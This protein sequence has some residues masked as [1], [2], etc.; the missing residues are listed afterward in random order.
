MRLVD[1]FG[2]PNLP[3]SV[4]NNK[5]FQNF[6]IMLLSMLE[7]QGIPLDISALQFSFR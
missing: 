4:R 7:T 1:S 2:L 6:K 3:N 5:E